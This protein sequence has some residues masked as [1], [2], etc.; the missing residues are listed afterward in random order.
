MATV[1]GEASYEDL[2]LSEVDLA[3]DASAATEITLADG[4]SSG[5]SGVSV[6]G[7]TVTI[8]AAGTYVLSG[9]LSD[10]QV[11]VNVVDD[12][13][14]LI[15]DGVDITM[16]D[17]PGIQVDDASNV[18]V[19]T[20][21]GTTNSVSDTGTYDE[22]DDTVGG[23]AIYSSADLFLAGEGTLVV[24]GGRNDGITSKDSLV[25]A[26]GTYEITATDDGIRGKDHLV[27]LDGDIAVDAT[28]DAL[29][30]DNEA[31][32][33]ESER[34]VGIVWIAGGS[35]DL[36]SGTDGI[37]A[38]NQVTIAGGTLA[39]DAGDDG[40]HSEVYL[41][42]GDAE[43]DIANSYEGLE[44][45]L[46]YLDGGDVSIVA[47]DD[48]INATDGSSNQETATQTMGGPPGG[49]AG[50][51]R[52]E[53]P[54]AVDSAAGASS[55]PQSESDS[56]A[57][58]DAVEVQAPVDIVED[59]VGIYID[60]GTYVIDAVGDGVDSNGN[61][62]MS[63]GVVVIA[64][65][66]TD[67]EGPIDYNGEFA[68]DGGVIAASG[69]SGM[70]EAPDGGEQPYVWLTF[71]MSLAAGTVISVVDDGGELIASY[72][73]EKTS[74]SLVLSTPDIESGATYTVVSGGSVAGGEEVGPLTVGG[75]LTGGNELGSLTAS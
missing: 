68:L 32:N 29:K 66:E 61:I 25:I 24:D 19:Y 48:G 60:G 37:D 46:I 65:P 21:A 69:A 39:I 13:V 34:F 70:A 38:A 35:L 9:T 56:P 33:D 20:A 23:A 6:D 72:T 42:I 8:S 63:G 67:R 2:D 58:T 27:I 49:T 36:R 51:E 17:A 75:T 74:A 4:A 3:P 43:I 44:A 71:N 15:L 45:A 12:D 5:G 59:N 54:G 11:V 18:I 7:D 26:S 30:S 16:S 50:G 55:A 22:T 1:E 28:G 14:A 62:Q 57:L 64:G 52:P 47:S 40:I 10:G 73:T 53:R 31:D 41:R